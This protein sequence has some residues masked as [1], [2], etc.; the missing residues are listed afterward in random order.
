MLLTARGGTVVA[1]F[2][3]SAPAIGGSLLRTNARPGDVFPGQS[4]PR[5][6][7]RAARLGRLGENYRSAG[8]AAGAPRGDAQLGDGRGLSVG[9]VPPVRDRHP[10]VSSARA[11]RRRRLSIGFVVRGAF[12]SAVPVGVARWTWR[13]AGRAS[14]SCQA[15]RRASA[16]HRG[17]CKISSA[18]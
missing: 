3:A 15:G 17:R 9:A 10:L 6:S 2:A 12:G 4:L 5:V 14:R 13:I 1:L 11:R 16:A 8:R 18:V 7:G